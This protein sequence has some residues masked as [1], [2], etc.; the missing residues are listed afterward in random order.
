MEEIKYI[1]NVMNLGRKL[2]NFIDFC[3]V[4]QRCKHP[5]R[6]FTF[7]ERHN[8]PKKSGDVFANAK[9]GSLPISRGGCALHFSVFSAY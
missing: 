2:R 8:L 6:S 7:E 5:N 4:Y 3:D 1:F 9:C